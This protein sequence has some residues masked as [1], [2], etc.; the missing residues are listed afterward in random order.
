MEITLFPPDG[1]FSVYTLSKID[2]MREVLGCSQDDFPS[3]EVSW[4]KIDA[5]GMTLR[6]GALFEFIGKEFGFW[7]STWVNKRL[8]DQKYS[9]EVFPDI[10]VVISAGK[11]D[12]IAFPL[13]GS[14]LLHQGWNDH[15][16][17]FEVFI[18]GGYK[19]LYRLW[20]SNFTHFVSP[21]E[22]ATIGK[23]PWE[24]VR[25]VVFRFSSQEVLGMA[26]ELEKKGIAFYESLTLRTKTE[27]GRKVFRFLAEEEK[28]HL[29][30]FSR[31]LGEIREFDFGDNDEVARYLGAIVEGGIL[32]KVLE[33]GIDPERLDVLGALEI[34]IQVEKESILFYQGFLPLV[35]STQRSWV[36]KIVE[37]EKKH[38][39]RLSELKKTFTGEKE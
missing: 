3:I 19:E 26:V 38:F 8:K 35:P 28:Q 9:H 20:W 37:E 27:D 31:L 15:L 6:G 13:Y 24:G 22:N 2:S 21:L 17:D 7:K 11:G 4:V 32:A 39:L 5:S 25:R 34:G 1:G 36:E 30:L 33:G 23:H 14:E 16:K 12:W 29:E 18:E 10:T